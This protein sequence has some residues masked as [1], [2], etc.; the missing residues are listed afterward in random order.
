MRVHPTAIVSPAARL[1]RDVAVGPFA[2]IEE[3][4]VIGDG[5]EIRAHAV[6]KRFTSLGVGNRVHEGAVL[7]GEPQDLSFRD[8]ETSLRDRRSQRHPRGGDHPSVDE[9][10]RDDRRG[11]RLLPDGLRTRGP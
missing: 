2:V 7:G 8:L 4:A 9:G 1:G 6:V 11:L 10:G 3:G 5:C